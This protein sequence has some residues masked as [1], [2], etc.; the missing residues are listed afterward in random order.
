MKPL[1]VAFVAIAA[2]VPAVAT[3]GS[4]P[5]GYRLAGRYKVFHKNKALKT[6]IWRLAP[7]CDTGACDTDITST[8]GFDGTFRYRVSAEKYV[9]VTRARSGACET[10]DGRRAEPAYADTI[11]IELTD[12]TGATGPAKYANGTREDVYRPLPKAK[13]L[14]CTKPHERSTKV[15]LRHL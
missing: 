10:S 4:D 6:R 15:H 3:A 12:F 9:L 14:G 2:L 7:R 13:A 11:T 5:E 8:T 1:I